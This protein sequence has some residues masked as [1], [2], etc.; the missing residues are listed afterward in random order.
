VE[1]TGEKNGQ[2]INDEKLFYRIFILGNGGYSTSALW[3][4]VLDLFTLLK[5]HFIAHIHNGGGEGGG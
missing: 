1:K 3:C 5:V 4:G 2:T